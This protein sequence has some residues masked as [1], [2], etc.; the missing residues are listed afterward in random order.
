M[1]GIGIHTGASYL[2]RLH[3]L[4]PDVELQTDHQIEFFTVQNGV[5]Y[6]CPALFTRLSGT[7]RS[8]ALVMRGASKRRL[9]VRTVEHFLAAAFMLGL[10]ARV[11]ILTADI[12]EAPDVLEIPVLDGA[13]SEWLGWIREQPAFPR[14]R[15]TPAPGSLYFC[16]KEFEVHDGNRFVKISP[17]P[18]DELKTQFIYNVNFGDGAWCQQASFDIDWNDLAASEK[19]FASFIAPARTFGFVHELKAL[20]ARDL[21]RGGSL[22]NA[23]LLDGDRVVNEGGLKF[24]NELAAHKL[25]DGIGDFA[26]LGAPLVARIEC[27]QAGHSMHLRAVE[28]AVRTGAISKLLG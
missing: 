10:R 1:R 7:T 14:M 3:P 16:Q 12:A 21:A 19:I 11:E 8:T 25:L 26:L 17:L 27:N 15:R 28:E 13:A 22:K 5:E 6:S 23:L 4:R 2:L 20:Q 24:A 18:K 9:E